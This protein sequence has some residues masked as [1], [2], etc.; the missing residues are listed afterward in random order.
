L[1]EHF[2][3][4]IGWCGSW[5]RQGIEVVSGVE[6][7]SN[8]EAW[9][10][11]FLAVSDEA[12][13]PISRRIPSGTWRIHLSGAQ[14]LSVLLEAGERGAVLWP[15]CSIRKEYPPK[16]SEVHWCIEATDEE[17]Y[18]WAQKAVLQLHGTPHQVTES[19]RRKAHIAA[20][21]AA[22]FTNLALAEASDLIAATT[23]P[24]RAIHQLA[25]GVVQRCLEQSATAQLTGPASRDDTSTL[26]IHREELSDSPELLE[27]YD[28]LSERIKMRSPNS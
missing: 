1:G 6:L 22:N 13:D 19:Q 21:F 9:D 12:L 11:A 23:V 16:W 18:D 27:V 20:V 8:W 3:R 7:T 24:W 5:N 17:V 28:L 10:V 14:P 26:L 15:I 4:E 2:Q 25:Q